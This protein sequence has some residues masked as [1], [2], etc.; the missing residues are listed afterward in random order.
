MFSSDC[1]SPT[2][3]QLFSSITEDVSRDH[4]ASH[5]VSEPHSS[6]PSLSA[7]RIG[8]P[9]SHL[10]GLFPDASSGGDFRRPLERSHTLVFEKFVF[11]RMCLNI[12]AVEGPMRY[13][14]PCSHT[15][16]LQAFRRHRFVQSSSTQAVGKQVCSML[17]NLP[18]CIAVAAMDDAAVLVM[19][20]RDMA[21]ATL[22]TVHPE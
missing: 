11:L 8:L 19:C 5:S 3:T 21:H 13:I 2:Q 6:N 4:S 1:H 16:W 10:K 15:Q 22:W 12:I 7:F 17:S 18:D 14:Q 20:R 9:E